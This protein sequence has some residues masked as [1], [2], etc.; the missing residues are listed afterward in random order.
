MEEYTVELNQ[1]D[2]LL[3]NKL[4]KD[5]KFYR[6]NNL[7][8]E[9]IKKWRK[10]NKDKL[11]DYA[12][13]YLNKNREKYMLQNS[14]RRANRKGIPFSLAL[15]DIVIPEYCPILGIKLEF[16]G[17]VDTSPSIDRID[18][19]KGYHKDN[20]HVISGRANAIKRDATIEELVKITNYLLELDS[21]K[22]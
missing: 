18:N 8:K 9:N 13:K 16:G 19:S 22:K 21:N 4:L 3:Y 12:T 20:I 7:N 15:G 2:N 10:L 5:N 6:N 17:S 14:K 1:I 11:K